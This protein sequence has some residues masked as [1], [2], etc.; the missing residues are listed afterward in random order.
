MTNN[1]KTA[2]DS[3]QNHEQSHEQTR[4]SFLTKFGKLATVT[5]FALTALM[6]PVSSAAP[7]S[8]RENQENKHCPAKATKSK[9]STF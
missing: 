5:P 6:S 2:V 8:C 9:S 7:T 1:N 3:Q 4:R